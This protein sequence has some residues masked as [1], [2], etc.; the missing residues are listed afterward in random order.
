[1]MEL[2]KLKER[3]G[4]TDP[5]ME[6][7]KKGGVA[8][9]RAISSAAWA[10]RSAR[11][12]RMATATAAPAPVDRNATSAGIAAGAGDPLD[13]PAELQRGGYRAT[14]A[15]DHGS[16]HGVGVVKFVTTRYG[17]T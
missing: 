12:G 8:V 15:D 14:R 6:D 9:R 7:A 10:A 2:L 3:F 16:D 11:K 17:G 13:G 4:F 5:R 1:M